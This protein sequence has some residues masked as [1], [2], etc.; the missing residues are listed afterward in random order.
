MS[1][2]QISE[3]N[4]KQQS[5]I[6][7]L[8]DCNEIEFDDVSVSTRSDRGDDAENSGYNKD[9]TFMSEEAYEKYE[10]KI[11]DLCDEYMLEYEDEEFVELINHDAVRS[12]GSTHLYARARRSGSYLLGYAYKAESWITG[13][14]PKEMHLVM[15]INGYSTAVKT[16]KGKRSI[17]LIKG[18]GL[19]RTMYTHHETMSPYIYIKLKVKK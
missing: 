4:Q 2:K 7:E 16:V 17:S 1:K 5:I 19:K 9:F 11:R 13:N 12:S 10:S 6:N 3:I 18:K 14:T 15:D 8:S